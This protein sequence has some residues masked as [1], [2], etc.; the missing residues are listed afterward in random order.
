MKC[1]ECG[2]T[3]INKNGTIERN[4]NR[5]GRYRVENADYRECDT[6]KIAMYPAKTLLLFESKEAEVLNR[7][8]RALPVGEFITATEVA[9]ILGVTRQAVSKHRRIRRGFIYSTKIGG[10]NMY[11][12]KSVQLFLT[13]QDGR[14][15]LNPTPTW[16]EARARKAEKF[17]NATS[18]PSWADGYTEEDVE[19]GIEYKRTA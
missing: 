7:L 9:R 19:S 18:N 3:Y 11:H 1:Y 17:E 15:H 14:F 8:I 5:V 2:G 4:N 12:K 16:F 10:K 6:C 13:E